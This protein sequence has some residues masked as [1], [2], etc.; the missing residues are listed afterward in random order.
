M[1]RGRWRE[2]EDL[3]LLLPR[4][5]DG[6]GKSRRR[7]ES[8]TRAVQRCWGCLLRFGAHAGVVLSRRD[9][10]AVCVRT[11]GV[12]EKNGY[13]DGVSTT[14]VRALMM[15]DGLIQPRS[16]ASSTYRPGS[17]DLYLTRPM[18]PNT[19]LVIVDP[20]ILRSIHVFFFQLKK[21]ESLSQKK[22]KS[23]IS[24]D[25]SLKSL[26]ELCGS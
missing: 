23:L 20:Y 5:E 9:G 16:Q 6:R 15:T 7:C 13:A 4:E 25:A 17:N 24:F 10:A 19:G 1:W 26:A 22:R 2:L 3:G 14:V 11:G 8:T 12:S 21:N 18:T